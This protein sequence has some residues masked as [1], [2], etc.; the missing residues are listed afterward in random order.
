MLVHSKCAA[1]NLREL[2]SPYGVITQFLS[3]TKCTKS[4][5]KYGVMPQTESC[6]S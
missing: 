2:N 1:H 4:N 3:G 5:F 6:A